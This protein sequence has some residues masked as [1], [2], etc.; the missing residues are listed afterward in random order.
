MTRTFECHNKYRSMNSTRPFLLPQVWPLLDQI[1]SA[2]WFINWARTEPPTQGRTGPE[3]LI[4]NNNW[5]FPSTMT[6]RPQ[7][8]SRLR[9]YH[10]TARIDV[11]DVS[12]PWFAHN[13]FRSNSFTLTSV[14]ILWNYYV[15]SILS[16]IPAFA[17]SDILSASWLRT[18]MMI[19]RYRLLRVFNDGDWSWSS[20]D[21]L[22]STLSL[23]AA[24]IPVAPWTK[25]ADSR[26]LKFSMADAEWHTGQE[27]VPSRCG[28]DIC[29]TGSGG[30]SPAAMK[31]SGRRLVPIW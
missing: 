6:W 21:R 1:K 24:T 13:G 19:F 31:K 15:H 11:R 10:S 26:L 22:S 9:R 3:R 29:R 16:E 7:N 14:L 8:S 18:H 2:S 20:K 27:A 17:S 25:T 23:L 28:E 12:E 5:S 4:T 30:L